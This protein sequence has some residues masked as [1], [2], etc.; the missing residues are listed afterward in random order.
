M[1][2]P[3]LA[4][5]ISAA[6]ALGQPGRGV[7]LFG[8]FGAMRAAADEGSAGSGAAFGGAATTPF[9][10]R[11]AVDVQALTA[12]LSD[13]PD[14]RMRRILV[15]PG[16]QYRRGNG[17]ALWFIAFGPG[18]ERDR[19]TG[20]GTV[21]FGRTETGLTLHWRTGA[22]VPLARRLLVRGEFFWV[23]RYVLPT[24]GV[25]MSLGLRL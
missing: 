4:L 19:S 20:S 24:V 1:K 13:R 2:L 7:E 23:N 25:A 11:W 16:V 6:T 14:F 22:V 9:A 18:L 8:T 5:F 17:R 12:K 15:S 3:I 21:T 10:S